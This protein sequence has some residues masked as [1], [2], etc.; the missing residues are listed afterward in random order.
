MILCSRCGEENPDRAKFC[1]NCAQPL[2]GRAATAETRR[3]VT[4]LFA[5]VVN[6]TGRG[7]STDPESTRH[8]LARYFD[9]MRSALERHG[10]TVE[11]FI[12]DA[13]MAVF[14]IPTIHEDDALRAVRAA[15][16][17]IAALDGLNDQLAGSGWPPIAVRVGINTGEVVTGDPATGQTLVT[18]DAVNVAAR[19]EQAAGPGEVV[20]GATTHQLVRDSV[21]AEAL[22]ALDV[23]G[24]SSPVPAYRLASVTPMGPA[25]RRHDTPLVAR[26]R[27]MRMLG[28]AFD[29]VTHD[30]ACHL[31]TLL[32]GAGV[33]KSRL[34]HEFLAQVR[35]RAQVMRARCLPY[36]EGITYWPISELVGEAAGIVA[37]DLPERAVGKL[38]AYLGDADGADE[39]VERIAAAVGL[40]QSPVA[41]D[42]IAWGVRKLLET[43]AQRQPLVVVIDDLHWAEP[44]LLDLLEHIADLSRDAPILILAIGRPE[45]LD[46]RPHWGGGK[47]NATTILLE[48]LTPDQSLELI[49]NL[50][51]D[52]P[53]AHALQ[54]RVG[55]TAEGNP[56]FVE[57]LVAMLIDQ[58]IVRRDGDGWATDEAIEGFSVPPTVSALV[59]A[60]LDRLE[61]PER[62]LVGRASVVGKVFQRSA[63]AELLP[64][65]RRPQL[66]ARLMT[67][68]RKEMVRPD[69]SG[70]AGD[71]AF[72]FRHIL[73]RDAA[74][75]S[76][77]KEQRAE[78]HAQFAAWL[79][80]VSGDRLHEY[81]EVIAHH[82]EQAH[83]NRAELGLVD[84]L[85][86]DLGRRA[87]AYLR[88]A[89]LRAAQRR[90][91]TAAVSLLSRAVRLTDDAA[92]RAQLLVPLANA[93]GD[94]GDPSGAMGLFREAEQAAR[95]SGDELLARR[96]ELDRLGLEQMVDPTVD[97]DPMLQKA[98]Q[99]LRRATAAGDAR[100]AIA[101]HSARGFV[102]LGRCRWSDQLK[103][104]GAAER[105]LSTIDDAELGRLIQV[106]TLNALR[107]GPVP[108]SEALERFEAIEKSDLPPTP[109]GALI[110]ALMAMHG[111]FDEARRDIDEAREFFAERGMAM[112][113]GSVALHAG[114]VEWLAG[115]LDAAERAYDAGVE[116][117]AAV[118]ETGILSTITAM[119]ARV[120]YKAGKPGRA[121]ASIELARQ[122]GAPHDIATQAAWR[123]TAAMLAAD[124][125]HQA[126]AEKLVAEAV[127]MV[128][129]T[130][131]LELRG[132]VF[133]ALAH[134]HQVAGRAGDWAAGL[135]RALAEY[136]AKE[137]IVD[138]GR[139]RAELGEQGP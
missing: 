99:L 55:E 72:R 41:A 93:V 10:G 20:L 86:R 57:E 123:A 53:M 94:A 52:G 111:R 129:P 75:G 78:L 45:L 35:E 42:E 73:V 37:S 43:I 29:R 67:L 121:L 11:K 82:L 17:M 16:D 114:T 98:D 132:Q 27:E 95:D 81:Q 125:G 119:R 84:D 58:G 25:G 68:V 5:D 137:D 79:E 83:D 12:G 118:G 26:D 135:R 61:A 34:V 104:L 15:S 47:L 91:V 102:F 3:T 8:M 23:K 56:L 74:Y 87:A 49:T 96:A 133:E 36:G 30:Q 33:G 117:L 107:Y 63:I 103:E 50:L 77:P 80:G 54:E 59:A 21:V 128:E 13:V 76:L 64:P 71:E 134:V 38:R 22:P 138:G 108:V 51:G 109:L 124:A 66:G 130:D 46:V 131:F 89:G 110:A 7:E 70:A 14:G 88:T 65:D 9:A 139:V 90:D 112:R 97:D 39:V 60:R 2:A 136:A 24:K 62:D 116:G 122:T 115:D 100:A 19:L 105:L 126:E 31:F 113:V 120:Q 4:I 32:G 106:D 127:R 6:S 28:E 48:P 92:G 18:G 1:L 85:T 40:V 44:T 101:A 69:R